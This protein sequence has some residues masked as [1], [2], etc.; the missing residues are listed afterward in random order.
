MDS[1][2]DIT[3]IDQ[4]SIVIRYVVLN[5]ETRNLTIEE[6]FLGF[7]CIEQHGAHNYE[8]LITDILLKLELDINMCR[9]QGYNGAA[10]MSGFYSGVQKRIKDKVSTASYVHCCAHNMN[11][12]IADAVKSNQMALSFFDTVQAIFNF[13]SS[14][15][16]RWATL[17]FGENDAN[18]IKQKVLKKVCP[19]CWEARHV[20][21][22]ALKVRFNDVLKSLTNI[23]LTSQKKDERNIANA[24]KKKLESLEFIQMLCLWENILRPLYGVSQSLQCKN[25]NL[26]NACKDLEEATNAIKNLRNGYNDLILT[27][28]NMCDKWGISKDYHK[29]RTRFAIKHFDEVDGDRRLNITTENFKVQVF[30]PIIDTVLYQ[31]INRF[32]GLKKVT[33]NF[34]FLQPH[35]L[36]N[37]PEVNLIKESYD[38]IQLYINDVTTDFTRQLLSIRTLLNT[39]NVKSIE[40]LA[41]FILKNDYST[42]Y[43]DVLS[44][45]LIY[46]TL[47]VTVASAER[48]FSKL[49]LIKNYLRNNMSQDRLS[50]IGILN[51]EKTKANQLNIDKIIDDFSNAKVRR[52]NLH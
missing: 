34:T 2:L 15:A 46:L 38:F 13:F 7:F 11:L 32:Q 1:T 36:V 3:K 42:T 10:V 43:C 29:T 40:Q 20:S 30:L 26:H 31:I 48:S 8:Q 47:P 24:L 21:I 4:V 33:E 41:V 19:T 6:S 35:I 23:S 27:S 51:I 44:A 49:K 16:P 39:S 5:Y 9:G 25:T 52:V 45:A 22:Y 17:A 12:V 50:N 14:S 28:M 37:L 18:N